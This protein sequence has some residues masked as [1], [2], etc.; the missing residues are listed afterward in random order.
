MVTVMLSLQRQGEFI[1]HLLVPL[2]NVNTT[3]LCW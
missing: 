1:V 2:L 3:R